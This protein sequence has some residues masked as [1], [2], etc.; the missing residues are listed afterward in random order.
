LA[1]KAYRLKPGRHITAVSPVRPIVVLLVYVSRQCECDAV[2][3]SFVG[4]SVVSVS[5]LYVQIQQHRPITSTV[6]D[7]VRH[8]ILKNNIIGLSNNILKGKIHTVTHSE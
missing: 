3:D 2:T 8:I 4:I 5:R 6:C 7:L 1:S